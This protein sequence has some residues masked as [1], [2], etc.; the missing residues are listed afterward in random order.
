MFFW[1]PHPFSC[2]NHGLPFEKEIPESEKKLKSFLLSQRLR[3]FAES[4]DSGCA[5]MSSVFV[6]C[7]IL[8]ALIQFC[9]CDSR[10]LSVC[11]CELH[12]I[13]AR[14]LPH[15]GVSLTMKTR[16]GWYVRL[17]RIPFVRR[18]FWGFLR[19]HALKSLHLQIVVPV[20]GP[21]LG[22]ARKY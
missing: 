4:L 20:F 7:F 11:S 10:P 1:A 12:T 8:T 17:V 6:C 9:F 22:D 16:R 15:F 18:C 2:C 5:F 19:R 14:Y 3:S 13:R 21:E